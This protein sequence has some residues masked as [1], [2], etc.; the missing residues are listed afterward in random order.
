MAMV[1]VALRARW[2]LSLWI[3]IN[4]LNSAPTETS[5]MLLYACYLYWFHVSCTDAIS[6]FRAIALLSSNSCVALLLCRYLHELHE[7]N[8]VVPHYH[9]SAHPYSLFC[10]DVNWIVNFIFFY[11]TPLWLSYLIVWI[12]GLC[13]NVGYLDISYMLPET[14]SAVVGIAAR[15]GPHGG[16]RHGRTSQEWGGP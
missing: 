10:M 7:L 11:A 8:L 6:F 16:I 12:T 14:N 1:I 13:W 2:Y 15:K 4:V 9:L 3:I 5:Y